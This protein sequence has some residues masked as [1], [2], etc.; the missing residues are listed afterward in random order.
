M[1]SVGE[2]QKK[3]F[4]VESKKDKTTIPVSFVTVPINYKCKDGSTD[5]VEVKFVKN[6]FSIHY[7]PS[8][9]DRDKWGYHRPNGVKEVPNKD[10]GLD[11]QTLLVKLTTLLKDKALVKQVVVELT[12]I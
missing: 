2:A 6:R 3:T 7:P 4:Y 5:T 11:P 10:T 1:W 9:V 12:S 8:Y